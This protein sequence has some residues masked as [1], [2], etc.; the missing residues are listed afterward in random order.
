[1]EFVFCNG[2]GFGADAIAARDLPNLMYYDVMHDIV[3]K[4]KV[5]EMHRI[6]LRDYGDPSLLS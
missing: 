4:L 6:S 3:G 5:P 2:I 1:M